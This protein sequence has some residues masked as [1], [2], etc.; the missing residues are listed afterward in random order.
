MRL[1]LNLSCGLPVSTWYKY[2]I[3]E[4][5]FVIHPIFTSSNIWTC[6]Y[7]LLLA[8]MLCL[9]EHTLC[10]NVVN[11]HN[12]WRPSWLC[13]YGS[14]I[15]NYL[16]NQNISPLKLWVRIPLRRCVLDTTLCNKVCQWLSTGR[17]F[18]PDTP[19]SSTNKTDLRDITD[20]LLKVALNTI[21]PTLTQTIIVGLG[22]WCVTPPNFQQYFTFL[23][24]YKLKIMM[25]YC[26]Y[27]F[28]CISAEK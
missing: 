1:Y 20:I 27:V 25:L 28:K 26:V 6:R 24:W 7:C 18:S 21:T 3:S 5:K 12:Y 17:W 2:F 10:L 14:W 9:V 23:N 4:D 13:S 8:S 19:V 16:C 15:Y 11:S 22:S